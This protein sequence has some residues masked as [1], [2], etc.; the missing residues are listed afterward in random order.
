M[1][2][3]EMKSL[4]LERGIRQDV[5]D[6]IELCGINLDHWLE[7]FHDT[8]DSVRK[9]VQTIRRHPLVPQGINL[10]GYIIDSVTGEL[11]EVK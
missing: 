4:M 3:S 9:T 1:N 5:L 11:T 6:T 8:E 2:G 10:H 7:G